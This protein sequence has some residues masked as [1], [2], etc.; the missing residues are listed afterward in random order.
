MIQTFLTHELT[1]FPQVSDNTWFQQDG[2][3]SHTARNTIKAINQLFPNYVIQEWGHF[4]ASE[5][6]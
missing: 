1:Q 2:A 6:A 4:L 3:T 5:V